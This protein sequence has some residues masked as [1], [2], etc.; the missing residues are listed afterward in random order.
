MDLHDVGRGRG[1]IDAAMARVTAPALVVSIT[2]DALYP[3]YQQEAL[4]DALVRV[5]TRC[6][7]QLVDSP[8]GHD[9]F[10]LETDR[11]GPTVAEFLTDIEKR[12]A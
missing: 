9:G 11:I 5:G 10:L 8:H 3:T 6:E 1:G 7:W 12:D 2:S 4:R